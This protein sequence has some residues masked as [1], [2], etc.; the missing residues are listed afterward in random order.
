MENNGNKVEVIIGGGHFTLVSEK[1]K[2]YTLRVAKYVD[3]QIEETR[4]E[5]SKIS[6]P[7]CTTLA[8][9]NSV[10]VPDLLPPTP[11]IAA[12]AYRVVGSLNDV[13]PVLEALTDERKPER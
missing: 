12:L 11:E 9:I 6:L 13:I 7:N 8:S 4:K 10:M 2:E 1:P 5:N 3:G